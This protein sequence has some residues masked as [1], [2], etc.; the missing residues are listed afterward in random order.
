MAKLLELATVKANS[1]PH[2]GFEIYWL[3]SRNQVEFVFQELELVKTEGGLDRAEFQGGMLPV[4]WLENYFG[5][6]RVQGKEETKYVVVSGVSIDGGLARII[7]P[8]PYSL[9]L[10][11]LKTELTPVSSFVLPRNSDD[12][13]G[14]YSLSSSRIVVVPDIGKIA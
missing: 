7:I 10:H 8:A 12:I 6:R 11:K 14:I 3:F 4:F 5:L 9:K 2:D 13:L 1:H